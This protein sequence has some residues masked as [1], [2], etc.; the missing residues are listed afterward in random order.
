VVALKRQDVD[1]FLARPDAARPVALVF[2]PDAGLVR[3]RADAI[4]RASVD[5]VNDPFA[6]A[7]L[8]GETLVAEPARLVEEAHTVPLFGGRRA[9]SVRVASRYNIAAAVEALLAAPVPECRV[10]IEAGDLRRNAPLR[11]LCERAKTAVAIGC[12]AD[13]DRGLA[14]LVDEE[15][16]VAGLAIAPD[17][18]KALVALIGG[19]RM[20]SRN[21]IRKLALYAHGKDSVTL[22]DV[23]AVVGDAS[24]R[25]VDSVVDTAF[26]GRKDEFET[27]F[28]KESTAKTA[29]STILSAAL[30]QLAQLHKGRLAI[31]EGAS[32]KEALDAMLPPVHFSRQP[33]VEA[34]LRIWTAA[35]LLRLMGQ[36][37]DAAL[38]VRRQS[39]HAETIAQRALLSIAVNARRKE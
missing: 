14:R 30:R 11:V 3:E 6:L 29:P 37:S 39:A 28:A 15:L 35:R 2:G 17:A 4:I 38:D 13:D 24:A 22:D 12:Y 25:G 5:D 36:L 20:A 7:R 33:L 8:E 31:E 23:D 9:V 16:R 21:E 34:A 19:D 18:R 26:A 1:T 10:V 27:E 32:T